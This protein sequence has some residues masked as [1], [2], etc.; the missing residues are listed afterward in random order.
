MR[1]VR[2]RPVDP[3]ADP[4]DVRGWGTESCT[5]R[6]G[7]RREL[8]VSVAASCAP[9]RSTPTAL[10][11]QSVT[12]R[13]L[14]PV[15]HPVARCRSSTRPVDRSTS[16]EAVGRR[17]TGRAPARRSA[18]RMARLRMRSQ[19]GR[20]RQETPGP[21]VPRACRRFTEVACSGL[22]VQTRRALRLACVQP[23]DERGAS[24]LC[25][26]R[27]SPDSRP[28]SMACSGMFRGSGGRAGNVLRKEPGKTS[29]D[30]RCARSVA[31]CA[32]G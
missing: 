11:A 15:R 3:E 25:H 29:R 2:G 26:R 19:A 30:G 24:G 20:G 7:P 23:C 13:N 8:V 4:Q 18:G 21:S 5:E 32:T 14:D 31:G 27:G 12:F 1:G 17:P 9:S 22:W 16:V 28:H 10:S 6:R